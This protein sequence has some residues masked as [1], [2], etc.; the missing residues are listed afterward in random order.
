MN[1]ETLDETKDSINSTLYG[2]ED[3]QLQ[4]LKSVETFK[5]AK[6]VEKQEEFLYDNKVFGNNVTI[7]YPKKMGNMFTFFYFRKHPLIVI[8][9]DCKTSLYKFR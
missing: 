8:G 4:S 6:D 9:P 5:T 3:I 7:Q 2:T 1:L